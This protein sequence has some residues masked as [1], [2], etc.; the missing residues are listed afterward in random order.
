M[1]AV[2]RLFRKELIQVFRDRKLL[3]STLVL[4]V[5][6]M[7]VFMFGPSLFLSLLLQGAA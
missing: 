2:L 6:L 3:F 5:L 1:E 4:P 7:P